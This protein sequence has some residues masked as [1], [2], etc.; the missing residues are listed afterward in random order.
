MKN[1]QF[2]PS[3]FL[4]PHCGKAIGKIAY[5]QTFEYKVAKWLDAEVASNSTPGFDVYKSNHF[6][7][8]TFQVKYASSFEYHGY[9]TYKQLSW[10]WISKNKNKTHPDFFI[11]FG[12]MPKHKES[13]FLISRSDFY[14][15]ASQYQGRYNLRVSAKRISDRGHYKYT[16]KIW[17]FNVKNPEKNLVSAILNYKPCAKGSAFMIK[18]SEHKRDIK[19]MF[20]NGMTLVD[21]GKKYHVS[22]T[23]IKRLLHGKR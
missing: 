18:L 11:L 3:Y 15:Y 16:P 12:L 14:E 10:H 17:L 21:I 8:L 6:P 4:C 5:F 9:A 22:F 7:K 13:V 23:S 19:R 20:D 2:Q 1:K